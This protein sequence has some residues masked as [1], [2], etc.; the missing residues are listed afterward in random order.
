M[1]HRVWELRTVFCVTG[2]GGS[3]RTRDYELELVAHLVLRGI[4]V[5]HGKYEDVVLEKVEPSRD[6]QLEALGAVGKVHRV[7]ARA[8]LRF[9]SCLIW[10]FDYNFTNY[11]FKQKLEFQTRL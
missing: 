11:M 8:V 9:L 4:E 2:S 5:G 6:Y 7:A 10:G 1:V 3:Q